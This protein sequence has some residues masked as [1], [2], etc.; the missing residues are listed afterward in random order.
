MLRERIDG[1]VLKLERQEQ[2][3]LEEQLLEQHP[4]LPI[5]QRIDLLTNRVETLEGTLAS[6][7]GITLK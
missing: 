5:V 4:P 3:E 6:T 1:V 2:D 7:L